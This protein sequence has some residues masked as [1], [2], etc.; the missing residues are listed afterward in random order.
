MMPIYP[1]TINFL[2]KHGLAAIK[3]KKTNNIPGENSIKNGYS[4]AGLSIGKYNIEKT[5]SIKTDMLNQP[6]KFKIGTP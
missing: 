5:V 6:I 2:S 3:C 1:E 4:S